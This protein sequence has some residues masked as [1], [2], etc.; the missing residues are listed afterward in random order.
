M[1]AFNRK[2]QKEMMTK[3]LVCD[4]CC[5]LVNEATVVEF[6]Q[7]CRACA[8]MWVY[9]DKNGNPHLRKRVWNKCLIE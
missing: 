6:N 1:M 3:Y 4:L 7:V 5:N 2:E 9:L 8:K